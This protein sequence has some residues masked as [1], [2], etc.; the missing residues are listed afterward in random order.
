MLLANYL[1]SLYS[2]DHKHLFKIVKLDS[3]RKVC[4]NNRYD[5]VDDL[6]NDTE[7]NKKDEGRS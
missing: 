5:D 6:Y 2:Q 1:F 3:L 7:K 4:S